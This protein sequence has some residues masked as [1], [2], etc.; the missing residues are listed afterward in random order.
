MDKK[1][2]A[3]TKKAPVPK[4]PTKE[5]K[6]RGRKS[7]IKPELIEKIAG[8]IRIGIFVDEACGACG[9]GRTT[10][11]NWLERGRAER[12]RMSLLGL[13]EPSESEK[14]FVEFLNTVES[15]YDEATLRNMA[16][17]AKASERGDWRAASWW[18]EQAR[19]HKYGKKE[20]IEMT[21]ADGG[22]VKITVEMGELEEKISKV[23]AIRN[24]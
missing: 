13:T 2:G 23:L 18:L 3:V 11:Y 24:K 20:R 16:V 9:I 8:Y 15:A 5:P 1:S 19:P 22:A 10:F 6:K 12:E 17:I 21:G 4:T 7:L 14:E